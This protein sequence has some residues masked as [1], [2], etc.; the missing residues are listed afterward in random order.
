[1]TQEIRIHQIWKDVDLIHKYGV[2]RYVLILQIVGED[3]QVIECS[4]Y[5][6]PSFY[7]L[8]K[9]LTAFQLRKEF[10]ME[11]EDA[12]VAEAAFS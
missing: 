7:V 5:G 10:Q 6:R 3:I 12:F 2:S 8:P 1:M 4:Q 11:Q 9:T